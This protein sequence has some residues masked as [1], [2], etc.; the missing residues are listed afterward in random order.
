MKR[1]WNGNSEKKLPPTYRR[2]FLVC[3]ILPIHYSYKLFR[4]KR[5]KDPPD[6][7]KS[8]FTYPQ[9]SPEKKNIEES[10]CR[11]RKNWNAIIMMA[12]LMIVHFSLR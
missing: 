5:P 8:H 10:A 2:P 11:I 9:I 3:P 4:P 1:N 6:I 12:M 7:E